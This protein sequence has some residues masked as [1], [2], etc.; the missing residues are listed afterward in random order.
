MKS[1][2]FMD[3]DPSIRDGIAAILKL[4]GYDVDL[5]SDGNEA[6]ELYTRRKQNAKPYDAVIMDLTIPGGMGGR[7]A[8]SELLKIDPGVR[9][10]VTS[11]YYA[12]PVVANYSQFGFIDVV[13]KPYKIGKLVEAITRA[14]GR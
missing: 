1:I 6:I 14:A 12:D 5:A 13:V 8:I 11:G 4:E 2:L 9:A 7:I 10:I 3:D